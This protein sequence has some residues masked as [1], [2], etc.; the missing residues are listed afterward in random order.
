VGPGLLSGSQVKCKAKYVV[1]KFCMRM[2]K[3]PTFQ[4]I[5]G[6][7]IQMDVSK[8]RIITALLARQ[9]FV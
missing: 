2:P 3:I 8:Q 9:K 1:M 6:T 4:K 7:D 5:W